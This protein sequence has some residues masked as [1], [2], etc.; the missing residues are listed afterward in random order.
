MLIVKGLPHQSVK[1]SLESVPLNLGLHQP[2]PQ[3]LIF[4]GRRLHGSLM[5]QE[6]VLLLL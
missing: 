6:L 5:H 1:I 2:L 4:R 3:F